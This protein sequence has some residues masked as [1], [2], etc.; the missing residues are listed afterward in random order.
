MNFRLRQSTQIILLSAF[1]VAAFVLW[2][3]WADIDQVSRARGQ[4]IPSGRGRGVATAA[5]RVLAGHA[6]TP[7]DRGGLGIRRLVAQT[8]EDNT[9]SNIVLDRL[10]FTIWGRETAADVLPDGRAVDAL[11]WELL[12]D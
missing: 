8:A 7:R 12:R 6:L 10:G 2:S 3:L 4:V 5:S 9:G 11:H 1:A